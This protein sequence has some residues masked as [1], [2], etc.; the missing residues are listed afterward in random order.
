MRPVLDAVCLEP[1]VLRGGA[2][3]ALEIAT[4][5]QALSAPV[6]RREQRHGD[7]V[8]LRRARSVIVVVDRMRAN[9]GA[10]IAAVAGE[11]FVAERLRPAHHLAMHPRTLTAFAPSL[12]HRLALQ[13]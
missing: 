5:M 1:L 10:E 12:L 6:R 9:V 2:H 13:A 8:P 11:L 7:L 4:R 3:K